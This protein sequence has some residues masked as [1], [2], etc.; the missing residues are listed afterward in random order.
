MRLWRQTRATRLVVDAAGAV[1]GVEVLRVPAA[2]RRVAAR[3]GD[4]ALRQSDRRR[5]GP[6]HK[7]YGTIIRHRAARRRPMR[8]RVRKGVVLSAGGLPITAR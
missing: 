7:L 5:A 3:R 8:V 2:L 6:D 4:G 1:V